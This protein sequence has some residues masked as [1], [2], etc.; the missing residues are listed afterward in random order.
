MFHTHTIY[1]Y[2]YIHI[3]IYAY[4]YMYTLRD[5]FHQVFTSSASSEALNPLILSATTA[6]AA[7]STSSSLWGWVNH[8]QP[9]GHMK[10]MMTNITYQ[11][12]IF[13]CYWDIMGWYVYYNIY[14]YFCKYVT[15]ITNHLTYLDIILYASLIW[16]TSNM[17]TRNDFIRLYPVLN[18]GF[19]W[20]YF[21]LGKGITTTR[22]LGMN[23]HKS[24]DP[25]W[26]RQKA[27][28]VWTT[29][30]VGFHISHGW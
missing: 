24:Q 28:R 13:A 7:S 11:C 27:T 6:I 21:T 20:E 3:Y 29:Q 15:S 5:G 18:Q 4:M 23:I 8:N 2:V 26:V 30:N 1:V 14:I 22:I 25:S 12:T 17:G 19:V 16:N 10:H 9:C